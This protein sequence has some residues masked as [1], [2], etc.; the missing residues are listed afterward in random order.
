[1]EINF[2]YLMTIKCKFEARVY[3]TTTTSE[4]FYNAILKIV[5]HNRCT[6]LILL[7]RKIFFIYIFMI[8]L[9]ILSNYLL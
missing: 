8:R 4:Y 2:S 1:M 5:S 7:T 9:I 3:R 6:V